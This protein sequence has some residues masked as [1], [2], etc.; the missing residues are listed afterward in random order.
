MFHLPKS[1]ILIDECGNAC[2]C[3]FGLSKIRTHP[4]TISSTFSSSSS[5]NRNAASHV[6]NETNVGSPRWMAP[7]QMMMGIIGKST[8]V[9]SFGMTVYEVKKIGPAFELIRLICLCEDIH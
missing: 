8:D 1:N 4:T 2:L 9:Y 3:D 6:G 5:S 7:E